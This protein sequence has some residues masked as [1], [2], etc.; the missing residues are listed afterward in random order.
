M[1]FFVHLNRA[2]NLIKSVCLSVKKRVLACPRLLGI[3]TKKAAKLEPA[4]NT[5]GKSCKLKIFVPLVLY[6]LSAL[7]G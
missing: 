6:F 5:K 7:C 1:F 2:Y 4:K 3:L